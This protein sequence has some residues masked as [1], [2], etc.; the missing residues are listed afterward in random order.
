MT[1]AILSR[2]LLSV[3]GNALQKRL[4]GRGLSILSLWL[5]TY[6]LMLAPFV[7]L[8]LGHH[9]SRSRD[10]WENALLG[11]LL[12]AL[13]NLAMVAA[14]RSTDLSVFGP[15]NAFRPVM[16]LLFGWA[17][18]GETPTL[19]GALGV[20]VIVAGAVILLKRP[21]G[22]APSP[23]DSVRPLLFRGLG[24]SLSTIGAVFLKRAA[25]VAD[26]ATVLAAWTACGLACLVII[27]SLRVPRPW[28]SWRAT[29]KE[30]GG[31]LLLHALIF[32]LM[33]WITL[34][35]FVGTLLAYSFAYFQLGMVLQVVAG[36]V[37]FRE[38]G[39]WRR[40]AGCLV[41]GVGAGLMTWKG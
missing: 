40:L 6:I 19:Y 5:V 21:S 16:A 15:L 3:S 23:G 33:Q 28:A 18:L 34:K 30:S 36:V 17:F 9:P 14:L 8:A 20:G 2:V 7:L 27:G 1:R 37:L 38:P 41:M 35:I 10:F 24:L 39:I 32:A 12:D 11:G 25:G 22:D 29:V 13:G 26:T 31:W 4:A